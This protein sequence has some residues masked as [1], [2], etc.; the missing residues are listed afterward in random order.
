MCCWLR[1]SPFQTRQAGGAA[2]FGQTRPHAIRCL[3]TTNRAPRE[4]GA[5]REQREDLGAGLGGARVARLPMAERAF[6][7]RNGGSTR[8]RTPAMMRLACAPRGCSVPPFGALR[9]SS[10]TQTIRGIV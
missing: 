1:I 9:S 10:V 3:R 2:V 7:P 4:Q 5:G 6:V 8:A